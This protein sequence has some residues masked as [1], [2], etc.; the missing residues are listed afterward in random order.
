MPESA[1]ESILNQVNSLSPAERERLLAALTRTG[2]EREA[3][4]SSAWGKYA[5][6]VSPVDEFLRRK[7]E[8]TA[9]ED[10]GTEK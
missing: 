5:G 2:A 4:R 7:H 3:T 9:S 8:E 6:L 10:K 1:V